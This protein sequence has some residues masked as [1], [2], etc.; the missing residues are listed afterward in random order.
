[1]AR[2][3]SQLLKRTALLGDD[4]AL[5]RHKAPTVHLR[6]THLALHVESVAGALDG[7][8]EAVFRDLAPEGE[9]CVAHG[10]R[11]S[12][13]AFHTAM[14]TFHS[15]WLAMRVHPRGEVL[16][17]GRQV[18]LYFL[19]LRAALILDAKLVGNGSGNEEHGIVGRIDDGHAVGA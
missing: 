15:S 1:M 16:I 11:C 18:G 8:V 14:S 12:L 3:S 17:Q 5:R 9:G 10:E 6:R 7:H 2:N 4:G 19:N 13:S